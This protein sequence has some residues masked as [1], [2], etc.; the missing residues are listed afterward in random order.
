MEHVVTVGKP[1]RK[2]IDSETRNWPIICFTDFSIPEEV[3]KAMW[4]ES[5]KNKVVKFNRK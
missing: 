4:D 3:R 2:L 1:Y 5:Q